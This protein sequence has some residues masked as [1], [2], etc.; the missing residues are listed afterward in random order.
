MDIQVRRDLVHY[1][2]P[3]SGLTNLKATAI[4]VILAT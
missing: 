1:S 4:Q 2:V 3:V